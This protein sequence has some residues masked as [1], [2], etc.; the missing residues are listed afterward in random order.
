MDPDTDRDRDPDPPIFIHDL[1]DPTKKKHFFLQ[2]FSAYYFLKVHINHFSN[3]KI[4]KEAT[5]Q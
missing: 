3:I 5:K 2:S 4:H 1:Q